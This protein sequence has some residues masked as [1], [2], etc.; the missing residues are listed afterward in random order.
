MKRLALAPLVVCPVAVVGAA[1]WVSGLAWPIATQAWS[2]LAPRP[3]AAYDE[4]DVI[5]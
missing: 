3:H 4:D 1:L 5:A 2:V